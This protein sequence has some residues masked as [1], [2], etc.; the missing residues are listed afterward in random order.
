MAL[1]ADRDRTRVKDMLARLPG[2]VR[3]VNFTQELA[4]DYCR[5]T[6]QLL[7][8]LGELSSQV[9]VEVYNFQVDK[10]QVAKY[11]IDKI[12]ATV[13]EGLKDY[14]IRLYGIPLGYEFASLLGAMLDVSRGSTDLAPETKK[15]LAGLQQPM[16]LQVYVTPT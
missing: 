13:V 16:H 14:G 2:S 11:R 1:L 9:S 6:E 15:A 5:E 10:D 8:E 3:L 4:C 7:R 12:P